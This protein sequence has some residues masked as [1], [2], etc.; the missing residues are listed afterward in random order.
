MHRVEIHS[1]SVELL[2][3]VSRVLV[4]PFDPGEDKRWD[5]IINRALRMHEDDV[6]RELETT[7]NDFGGRHK[8]INEFWE[9]RFRQIAQRVPDAES[10]SGDR[11]LFIGA[12]FSHEYSLEAAALFNPSIVADPFQSGLEPDELR[13][14]MSLRATG[15]GHISSIE[16][17]TGVI[18][19]DY[20][21]RLD[22]VSG[23][24]T[25]PEQS[26]NPTYRKASFLHKLRELEIEDACLDPVMARLGPLF[27]LNDLNK[28][29]LAAEACENGDRC[30]ADNIMRHVHWLA[31]SNYDVQFSDDIPISERIVFPVS[32]NESNG[33]EDARF[34][35]FVDDDDVVTYYAT[36]TAYN[37]TMILPQL[38]ETNDFHHFRARV[39]HGSAVQNKGM[40]LFP[41]RIGEHYAMLSRQDDENLFLMYSEDIH[42]WS[43]PI[44][45][46][47]PMYPWEYIKI[48]NCGSPMETPE[49]WLV[50]THGVGPMR[51]Y[52][53]GA[54]LLD[55]DDPTRVVRALKEPLIKPEADG[56]EGY[57]P[58][59]V[60]TC[61]AL[62]HRDR[63]ILPYGKSDT[64]T[65]VVTVDLK[66]LLAAME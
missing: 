40:A 66:D 49:G 23:F 63:V 60:Y 34:V 21:V 16:F 27:S 55:L 61:G 4:R 64:L 29:I 30:S 41:R 52:C 47:E 62:I 3:D 31:E 14:I 26:K 2:P 18:G 13:I 6:A 59:V 50:I 38:M 51:Q 48:G 42:H 7:R 22:D 9:K 28:A 54:I 57:V 39:L 33:I 65:T 15:E 20:S 1:T 8:L 5:N 44:L 32:T 12:L 46:R 25:T 10:L 56:R 24:V 43:A 37:G 35:R 19:A 58:N 45:I 53:L 36:Y 11:Q 17:R